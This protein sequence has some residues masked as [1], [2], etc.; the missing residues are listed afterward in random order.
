VIYI[1]NSCASTGCYDKQPGRTYPRNNPTTT[2]ETQ[3]SK[4]KIT[5]CD[6]G[7]QTDDIDF[8]SEA[9]FLSGDAK[10]QY[11]TGLSSYLSLKTFELVMSPFVHSEKSSYYWRCF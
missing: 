11:Y 2:Q 10:A 1:Q 7:V 9:Y 4:L 6:K 3:T 5:M 8:F